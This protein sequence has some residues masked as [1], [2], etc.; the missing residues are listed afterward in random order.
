MVATR[1][2]LIAEEVPLAAGKDGEIVCAKIT[3]ANSQPLFICA[4][5]R[6]PHDTVSALDS[7]ELALDELS[8]K[9]ENN[10]RTC[11]I[12]AGDFNAPGIDWETC[13]IKPDGRNKGMCEKLLGTLDQFHLT[14]L[15]TAPTRNDATLDLFC[16][17]KPG[18][19]KSCSLVPG[20]SDHD[21]III[22]RHK[23]K[24]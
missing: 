6:P 12:V 22:I 5:Y 20:I 17:N 11:V 2:G 14:Q 18:L 4:Y 15:V 24:S 21:G 23:P 7:L 19:V 16:T 8:A 3:L 10:P 13:T 9:C 1:K